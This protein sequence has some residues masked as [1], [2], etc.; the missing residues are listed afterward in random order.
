MRNGQEATM[1]HTVTSDAPF[2]QTCKKCGAR[3]ERVAT[4]PK[5]TEN[6]G[7]D[8]Y[9]CLDCKYVEWLPLELARREKR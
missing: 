4:F 6:A 8:V 1:I 3:S 7:Y 5:S 2:G 9:Q